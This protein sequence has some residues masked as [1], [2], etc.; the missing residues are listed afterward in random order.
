MVTAATPLPR[1]TRFLYASSSLGGEALTQSR[2][3]WLVY[4]YAPP[5]DADLPELLTPLA[6]GVILTLVRLVESLDDVLIGWW[7]DRTQS[8]LGRRLPFIVIAT[9]FAGLFAALL[10]MPP[11]GGAVAAAW[12]AATLFG[13]FFFSTLSGGPY[14]ALFPEVATTT[15]DRLAVVGTRVYFGA[16][17]GA[18]GL[19]GASLLID[20]VGFA[21]MATAMAIIAVGCRYLGTAGV[22]R[23]ASRTTPPALVSLRE[24]LRLTVASRSFL[25]FLPSFVLFQMGVQLLL[26]DLPFFVKAVLEVEEEDRWVAGLTAV[27]I[28]VVL[29]S[30]PFLS[31]AARRTSK[32][33]VYLL[34]MLGASIVF[35]LL[36]LV[37]LGPVVPAEVQLV[38]LIAVAGVP[39]A[40]AYLFPAALTADIIDDDQTRSGM[41]REATYFGA[42]NLVEKTATSLTP[43]LLGL[44]L[45]LGRTTESQLGVRLVGVV[46]GAIVFCG[47]LVFRRY[48][49]EDDPVA[50]ASAS[51][52][53]S[54]T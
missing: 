26:A 51:T 20:S 14:E 45:V 32:R 25:L 4:Y 15:T 18:V 29:V 42:Q 40:G 13:Y 41:R 21:A 44:L 37:G 22:W 1:H 19:V 2:S 23:R 3:L 36:G 17:G 49:L 7:S 11:A 31:R 54:A 8:R 53:A 30:V 16:V 38:V 35:P 33:R 47:Y 6:V 24:A 10:F 46:A 34:S 39:L 5:E 27:A 12:L 43:L 48:R 9:P 28:V 52:S 50:R